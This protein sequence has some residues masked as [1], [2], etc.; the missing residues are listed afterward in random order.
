MRGVA[1]GPV[2]LLAWLLGVTVLIF[3]I[4]KEVPKDGDTFLSSFATESMRHGWLVPAAML[5]LMLCQ[6]AIKWMGSPEVFSAVRACLDIFKDEIFGDEAK[7]TD[8]VTLFRY[9]HAW[10]SPRF[11][12]WSRLV[13]VERSG[14]VLRKS[15]VRL[16]ATD[17]V[18]D[19]EGIA[20]VSF[21]HGEIISVKNLEDPESSDEATIE[22]YCDATFVTKKWFHKEQPRSR[23]LCGLPIEVRGKRWGVIVIDS[24]DIEG[25]WTTKARNRRGITK[26]V[27]SLLGA[28]EGES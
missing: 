14:H 2:R 25:R 15:S 4:L 13:A 7:V 18:H 12:T 5:V 16:K 28:G 3:S 8:R 26:I 19:A 24:E 10:T 9:I 1:V 21:A 20:G 22:A 11:W 27:S 23:S 17:R 6:V